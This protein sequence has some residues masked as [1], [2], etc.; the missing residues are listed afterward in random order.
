MHFLPQTSAHTQLPRSIK[1]PSSLWS[2][3]EEVSITSL[4]PALSADAVQIA[5]FRSIVRAVLLSRSDIY[6]T[7]ELD[8]WSGNSGNL[9]N[10]RIQ[11]LLKKMSNVANAAGIVAEE[12]AALGKA[13]KSTPT[14]PKVTTPKKRKMAKDEDGD[15]DD[16]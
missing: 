13:K 16:Y 8:A 3:N 7:P 10:A 15:L 12:V 9:I 1:M 2:T 6:K 11:Q 5:L 14:K 4:N